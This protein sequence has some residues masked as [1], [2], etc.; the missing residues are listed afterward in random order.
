MAHDENVMSSKVYTRVRSK[1]ATGVLYQRL[2]SKILQYSMYVEF[3]KQ[4][5]L[6][7]EAAFINCYFNTISR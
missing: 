3:L 5:I 7:N 6:K 2:F 1:A 4:Y